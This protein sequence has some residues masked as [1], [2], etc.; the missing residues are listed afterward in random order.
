MQKKYGLD[1]DDGGGGD[2]SRW[3][4][5]DLERAAQRYLDFSEDYSSR[6]DVLFENAHKFANNKIL[7]KYGDIGVADMEHYSR[8]SSAISVGA[9]MSVFAGLIALSMINK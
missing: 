8:V 4:E 7:Q 2:N 3:T 6:G 5:K 1:L 9:T